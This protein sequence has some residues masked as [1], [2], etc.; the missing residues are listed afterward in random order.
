MGC[1]AVARGPK[2]YTKYA[3]TSIIKRKDLI[4]FYLTTSVDFLNKLINISLLNHSFTLS[5]FQVK[6][7]GERF[8]ISFKITATYVS[9]CETY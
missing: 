6:D 9:N 8:A 7:E 4:F 2:L 3:E 1:D 5:G